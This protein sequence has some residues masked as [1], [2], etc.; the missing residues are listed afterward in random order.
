[1]GACCRVSERGGGCRGQEEV[2]VSTGPGLKRVKQRV[3]GC[4]NGKS[5]WMY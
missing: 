1:M 3:I 5:D 2:K 4:I